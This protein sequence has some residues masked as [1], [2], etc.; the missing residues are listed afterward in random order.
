MT[1][2]Q[3][4]DNVC[5]PLKSVLATLKTCPK[6]A[7]SYSDRYVYCHLGQVRIDGILGN[8]KFALEQAAK[9]QRGS[10]YL[11]LLFL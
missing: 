2:H 10:R 9:A 11:A 6:F 7:L 3:N 1:C 4:S 5:R 8:G